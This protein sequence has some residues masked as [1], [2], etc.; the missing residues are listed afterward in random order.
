[1]THKSPE[2]EVPWGIFQWGEKYLAFIHKYQPTS[3]D[4]WKTRSL[5]KPLHTDSFTSWGTL[6]EKWRESPIKL[7]PDVMKV[8][9]WA[10]P[11][12]PIWKLHTHTHTAQTSCACFTFPYLEVSPIVVV[13]RLEKV[14]WFGDIC[15]QLKFLLP[16]P[17]KQW[18]QNE[19]WFDIY[20]AHTCFIYC[21]WAVQ[22]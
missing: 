3:S 1:M 13:E 4:R 15:N 11:A 9:S 6:S 7:S 17:E 10:T 19:K 12:G 20:D 2:I 22:E 18:K 14:I 8:P 5:L 16:K 21:T